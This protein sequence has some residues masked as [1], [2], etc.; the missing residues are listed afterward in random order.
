MSLIWLIVISVLIV[1]IIYELI[2]RILIKRAT[3]IVQRR[4]QSITD[5]IVFSVLND[6]LN[7][8]DCEHQS[9]LVSDI[10]G[11]GVLSFEYNIGIDNS[12]SQSIPVTRNELENQLNKLAIERD[13]EFFKQAPQPFKITDWWQGKKKFHMDVTYLMNEA[14]YE[15]VQDLRKLG[16]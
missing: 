10:W 3:L 2:H 11:K 7:I 13:V 8:N 16:E 1:V 6:K 14:S 15:Y 4:A 12:N 9:Q 5:Q